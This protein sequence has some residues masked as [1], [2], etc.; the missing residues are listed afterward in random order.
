MGL[1]VFALLMGEPPEDTQG[2][3]AGSFHSYPRV[4]KLSHATFWVQGVWTQHC[5]ELIPPGV[6]QPSLQ[7]L[8]LIQSRKKTTH[9]LM[10]R[11]GPRA[12]IIPFTSCPPQRMFDARLPT[13]HSGCPVNA[14]H[15][16]PDAVIYVVNP[17][18]HNQL[19]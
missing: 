18:P 17:N 16:G 15:D 7:P 5:V 14:V 8:D 4:A 11:G 3:L 1:L 12:L 2:L 6:L 9:L 19:Q 10:A 13:L